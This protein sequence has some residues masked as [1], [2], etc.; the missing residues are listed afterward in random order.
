MVSARL[1]A[2]QGKQD[3]A[4]GLYTKAVAGAWWKAGPNQHPIMNEALLYA[5]GVADK[6]DAAIRS[7]E[8]AYSRPRSSASVRDLILVSTDRV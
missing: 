3:E 5:V 1:A 8:G 6:A 7:P 2:L 4:L